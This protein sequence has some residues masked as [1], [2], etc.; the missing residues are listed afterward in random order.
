MVRER[1]TIADSVSIFHLNVE[2]I[3]INQSES[4]LVLKQYGTCHVDE[5]NMILK[6]HILH[7][8]LKSYKL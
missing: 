8:P 7:F 2:K 6:V 3:T 4:K 1:C 5:D